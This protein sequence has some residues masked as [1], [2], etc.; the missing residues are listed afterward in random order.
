MQALVS[1]EIPAVTLIIRFLYE[2][3]C[4]PNENMHAITLSNYNLDVIIS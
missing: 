4:M 3:M 2:F 1:L